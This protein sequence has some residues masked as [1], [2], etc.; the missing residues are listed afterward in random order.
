M[1][2][3]N[4]TEYGLFWSVWAHC[5][6]D[7]W[8]VKN[9]T[10]S[11]ASSIVKRALIANEAYRLSDQGKGSPE[12]TEGLFMRIPNSEYAAIAAAVEEQVAKD[13]GITIKK[14]ETEGKN[15]DGSDGS[16]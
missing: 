16:T 1:I 4:G 7:D 15:A 2:K 12:L 13:S 3:I 10:A 11:Y 8:M 14:E 9:R 6:F 5:R